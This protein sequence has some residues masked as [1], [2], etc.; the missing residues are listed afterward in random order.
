MLEAA[1]NNRLEQS[2]MVKK[3]RG[4]LKQSLGLHDLAA[5][6]KDEQVFWPKQQRKAHVFARAGVEQDGLGILLL[7]LRKVE[8]ML[9]APWL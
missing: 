1:L 3:A 5:I 6:D 7:A 8:S 9:Q 2:N 4:L